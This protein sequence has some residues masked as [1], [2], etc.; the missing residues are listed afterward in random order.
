MPSHIREYLPL[1]RERMISFFSSSPLEKIEAYVATA[2]LRELKAGEVF[3][4][5]GDPAK[6]IYILCRGKLQA[7]VVDAGRHMHGLA[8]LDQ[9]GS[10]IGEQAFI[11]GHSFR[12]AH[13]LALEPSLLAMLEPEPF[14]ELIKADAQAKTKIEQMNVSQS[15]CK[16]KALAADFTKLAFEGRAIPPSRQYETGAVIYSANEEA[17]SA[18][19]VLS[20]EVHFF[21]PGCPVPHET[22]GTGFL[23]GDRDVLEGKPRRATA[24]AAKAS[25]VLLLEGSVLKA[26]KDSV[27][28]I[29]NSLDYVYKIPQLGS[30]YRYAGNI[31]GEAC[32]ITDYQQA[33]GSPLRVQYFP[34]LQR[35]EAM[36]VLT[37]NPATEIV[38]TLDGTSSLLL[39]AEDS[40][41]Y[42]LVAPEDWQQLSLAMGLLLRGAKLSTLQ[43]QAFVETA[44]LL[45]EDETVRAIG[46]SEVVCNCTSTTASALRLAAKNADT[47]EE[48]MRLT[49][50][51]TVCGGCRGRLP[52]FLGK[53]GM[54]LCQ[55]SKKPL[56]D[57]ALEVH[58]TVIGEDTLPFAKSGQHVQIEA[59]ID[60]RWTG[61]PYTI[62]SSTSK[63]L[64][65]GVKIEESGLFSNWM[66][67]APESS[68]VRI[69]SPQGDITPSLSD[70]RPLIYNVA[71]IG[72]TP[73]ISAVRNLAKHR[74]L[75]VIY[76]YHQAASA[77]YLDELKAAEKAGT[78]RFFPIETTQQG[79]QAISRCLELV[80]SLGTAEVI[81]CGP[82]NFNHA[83]QETLS[84]LD[85]VE[86]RLESFDHP[87]RGERAD[88]LPGAWR[89]KDFKPKCPMESLVEYKTTLTPQQQTEHF[90]RQFYAE[91]DVPVDDSRIEMACKN[92]DE[93]GDWKPTFDELAHGVRVA[94]R[95]AQRCVGRL[96]WKSLHLQD[97]RD[98]THPG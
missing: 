57:N 58:L 9:P 83:A 10:F 49:G 74:N 30:V 27:G 33:N 91:H 82:H 81:I 52:S 24:V 23:F 11:S 87:Q 72:V 45:V 76:S 61:R 62:V 20:G 68:L 43:R 98:L 79:R 35:T 8:T 77:A 19:F 51:G 31:N 28:A 55:I 15:E 38:T 89:I 12:N 90:L 59:M 3:M 5:E 44:H 67:N 95:N 25:E 29:L 16:L 4:E 40:T 13:V 37:T 39:D 17:D 70:P 92:L 36:R 42:G 94:W 46:G 78:I 47:V 86:V 60:G 6:F 41:L 69:S 93:G 84:K 96:Y 54:T 50:A 14:I 56:T 32:F 48:L 80:S 75:Y 88:P 21:Y 71:G 64:T 18:Y 53:T 1:I 34:R 26:K 22:V 2:T 63:H 85:N 97:Y 73:A 66:L 7:Y 65:I